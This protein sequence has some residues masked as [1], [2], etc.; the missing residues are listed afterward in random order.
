MLVRHVTC[1]RRCSDAGTKTTTLPLLFGG[2]NVGLEIR[3]NRAHGG[4]ASVTFGITECL[5]VFPVASSAVVMADNV[6]TGMTRTG[7]ALA[8][9]T[10]EAAPVV[11][12]L[13]GR[14]KSI[15][16]GFHGFFIRTG[17]HHNRL[18]ANQASG[19]GG[20]VI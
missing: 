10:A 7:I 20:N 5:N 19:N 9:A 14:N 4:R 13:F 12:S 8:A 15:D 3:S 6:V 16:N 2:N 1:G 11:Q 17:N 18:H